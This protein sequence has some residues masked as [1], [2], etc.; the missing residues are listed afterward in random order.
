LAEAIRPKIGGTMTGILRFIAGIFL[1]LF[2]GIW[3]YVAIK[4]FRFDP[5][6]E[7]P[8]LVFSQEF[9]GVAGL[10][11]TTVAAGTASVLGIEI[12]KGRM[13]GGGS[14]T[15]L[16]EAVKTSGFLK[17]GIFTYL[18]VGVVNL[19]A[20]LNDTEVAPEMVAAFALGALGWMGGAFSAVFQSSG[21]GGSRVG[22]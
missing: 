21:G 9:A 13:N 2:A 20:W 5:S 16:M 18:I 11:A 7:T 14:A 10:L 19:L 4:L 6:D 15:T 8:K 12:Q 1:A 3:L 22:S 17:I